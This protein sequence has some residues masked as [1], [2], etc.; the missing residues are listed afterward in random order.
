MKANIKTPQE[1]NAHSK[2]R[3]IWSGQ[4][5]KHVKTKY[6]WLF[7]PLSWFLLIVAI[8]WRVA[9]RSAGMPLVLLSYVLMF[10]AVYFLFFRNHFK[11][12]KRT[13]FSYEVTEEDIIIA[14]TK[15]NDIKV[16]HLALEN[17]KYA[18]YSIRK[19]GS[20][21]I[22]FNFPNDYKDIFRLIFANSGIG[23]FDENIYVFFELDD[24]E[25]FMEFIKPR[26]SPSV[27]FDKI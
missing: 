11:K 20:G 7:I 5:G 6:D 17:I 14:Y 21:T 23:K 24:L 2:A 18:A 12:K 26:L 3:T 1:N 8:F 16:E 19:D 22:Y 27:R 10:L 25:A 13:R 4:P 9:L 15:R